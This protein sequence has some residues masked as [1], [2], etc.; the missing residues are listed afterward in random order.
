MLFGA[1]ADG[2]TKKRFY[3]RRLETVRKRSFF[4]TL[5]SFVLG[6]SEHERRL[7]IRL[8]R[9]ILGSCVGLCYSENGGRIYDI[10]AKEK[11][12]GCIARKSWENLYYLNQSIPVWSKLIIYDWL[13]YPVYEIMGNHITVL[14]YF[15]GPSA[16]VVL[17]GTPTFPLRSISS[18]F[19]PE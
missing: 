17:A 11:S 9:E 7:C 19:L 4:R 10:Q 3:C 18:D 1:T 2:R 16:G 13:I 8:N 15:D 6:A 12:A 5:G 14:Y